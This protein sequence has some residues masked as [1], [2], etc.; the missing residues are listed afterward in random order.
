MNLMNVAGNPVARETAVDA[1][2]NRSVIGIDEYGQAIGHLHH[3]GNVGL[4][5]NLYRI[6]TGGSELPIRRADQFLFG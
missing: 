5:R 4:S 2:E 6:H 1:A 3:A